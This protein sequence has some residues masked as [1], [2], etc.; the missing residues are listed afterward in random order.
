LAAFIGLEVVGI[1]R[2]V[3]LALVEVDDDLELGMGDGFTDSSML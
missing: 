3:S 1:H 2:V